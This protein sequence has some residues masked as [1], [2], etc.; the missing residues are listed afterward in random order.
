MDEYFKR[1]DKGVLADFVQM[2]GFDLLASQLKGYSVSFEQ[3]SAL[4]S[5]TFGRP[6]HLKLHKSVTVTH[7][8]T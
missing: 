2:R 4:F 6:F 7:H 8:I 1:V 5:I 3:F